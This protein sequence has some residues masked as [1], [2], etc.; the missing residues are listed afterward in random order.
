[1]L[2]F[3]C[4]TA[5]GHPSAFLQAIS[6]ELGVEVECNYDIE[7]EDYNHD[8]TCFFHKDNYDEDKD[9]GTQDCPDDLCR[10]QIFTEK[11]Y[12]TN[13]ER[14]RQQVYG[15]IETLGVDMSQFTKKKGKK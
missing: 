11:Y 2:E 6:N 9:D 14:M 7:G 13:A 15:F 10:P 5:W 8:K 4:E 12:P 1:M 3:T